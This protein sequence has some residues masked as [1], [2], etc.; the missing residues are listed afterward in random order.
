MSDASLCSTPPAARFLWWSIRSAVLLLLLVFA[1]GVQAQ[2]TLGGATTALGGDCYRLTP[3]LTGQ[4]GTL[5]YTDLINLNEE[6]RVEAEIYLG[7]NDGGADGLAFVLQP[8]STGVGT[9]G[10]SLG[11]E[12]IMPSAIVEFD[13]YQNGANGDPFCD[14][15]A[16]LTDG[17]P[18][19]TAA[20]AVTAPVQA[21]STL[22][23]IEDGA[24][25]LLSIRWDPVL[26]RL[27]VYVDCNL[28]IDQ[29]IDLTADVFGGDPN[30]YWGF[31]GATGGL[32]N[33]HRVCIKF[34]DIDLPTDTVA[35]CDGGSTVLD[36]PAGFSGYSWSPAFGLDDPTIASPTASPSVSTTYVAAFVDPCGEV[37]TDT[38][39]VEV[40]SGPELDLGP[41][42]TLCNG[43]SL[44][45]TTPPGATSVTWPDGSS[46]ASFSINAAGTYP[47]QASIGLCP[48]YDTLVVTVA[49]PV[50][51]AGMDV[52][53]CTG[54]SV[55]VEVLPDPG[56]LLG[57]SLDGVPVGSGGSA[58]LS[59]PGTY[60]LL[61]MEGPCWQQDS[62][63]FSEDPL[64]LLDFQPDSVAWCPEA[65]VV[66]EPA[67]N[68]ESFLWEGG[69]TSPAIQVDMPG[70]YALI[71]SLNG[72][73]AEASVEVFERDDCS[74]NPSLPNAFSPNGDGVNDIFRVLFTDG[75]PNLS[76]FDFRVFSRWGELVFAGGEPGQGWDGT[77]RGRPAE[78]GSYV[79]QLRYTNN[80]QLQLQQGNLTLVR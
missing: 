48:S 1:G 20:T 5:W 12:G 36:A 70:L 68:A 35:I 57:W 8:L 28:R 65:S 56:V 26:T 30:V 38:F 39:H 75:C 46:G 44:L 78:L 43:A 10:G 71:A 32:S 33:E 29:T 21:S 67:S 63:V 66:L 7:T 58:W 47:V 52:S 61:A 42:T 49:N 18:I 80:G 60:V 74:C 41:D 55:F 51:D 27:Q 16:L 19:H 15:T 69:Q 13:T 40:G 76:G 72:C 73:I 59:T 79:Y 34:Y 50:A 24:Y 22:C 77:L 14:H 53:A 17:N 4:V 11:Y 25:H 62:L 31:T 9:S 45:L 6:V 54:D 2:F 37:F 3:N 64:P 23:N